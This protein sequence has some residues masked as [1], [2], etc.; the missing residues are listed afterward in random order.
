MQQAANE[1]AIVQRQ[2]W[3]ESEQEALDGVREAGVTVVYPEKSKFSEKVVPLYE[4]M[5]SNEKLYGLIE[6]IR[7]VGSGNTENDHEEEN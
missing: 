2:Y 6:E 7:N 4:N 3:A 5:K 1:S